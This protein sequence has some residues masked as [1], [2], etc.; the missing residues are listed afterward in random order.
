MKES[1]VVNASSSEVFPSKDSERSSYKTLNESLDQEPSFT[2][3]FEDNFDASSINLHKQ[4]SEPAH[5]SLFDKYAVFRELLEQ[6]NYENGPCGRKSPCRSPTAKDSTK[7]EEAPQTSVGGIAAPPVSAPAPVSQQDPSVDR[8]AALREISLCDEA[9][10]NKD[11]D[12]GDDDA[13]GE[14]GEGERENDMDGYVQAENEPSDKEDS[15]TEVPRNDEDQD[16]LTLSAQHSESTESPTNDTTTVKDT[17]SIMETTIMEEEACAGD[18]AT[19]AVSAVH[20]L[21]DITIAPITERPLEEEGLDQGS[22][23]LVPSSPADAR[24]IADSGS[25]LSED[26]EPPLKE[27]V[28]PVEVWAKFDAS[29]FDKPASDEAASPWSSDGKEYSRGAPA[30]W[31]DDSDREQVRGRRRRTNRGPAWREDE[32]SEEGPW[33]ENG[34]SDR[35]SLYDDGPAWYPEQR[36]SRRRKISPWRRTK[37]SREPSPWDSAE[38]DP[39][40][41]WDAKRWAKPADDDDGMR[42]W[43]TRPKNRGSSWE[44]ERRRVGSWEDVTPEYEDVRKRRPSPWSGEDR[45]SSRESMTWGDEERYQRRRYPGEGER[46]RHRGD[47]RWR[48]ER[49][50]EYRRRRDPDRD[51]ARDRERDRYAWPRKTASGDYC[52]PHRHYRDRDHSHDSPWDDEYSE[53]GEDSPHFQ[54]G[55]S[56]RKWRWSRPGSGS[57]Q[58]EGRRSHESYGG[59]DEYEHAGRR[60]RERPNSGSVERRSR[61]RDDAFNSDNEH[62]YWPEHARSRTERETRYEQRSQ[63]L[64]S[65]RSNRY[66]KTH[67]SPFEDDFTGEPKSQESSLELADGS[68]RSP[69][70]STPGTAVT[71]STHNAKV[72]RTAKKDSLSE[73]EEARSGR[74]RSSCG[75]SHRQSPFEDDFTTS[76]V[77]NSGRL[78]SASSDVSDQG[79]SGAD[80]RG[81]GP[82][83]S[84]LAQ[85]PRSADSGVFGS[86]SSMEHRN[87]RSIDDVFLPADAP[88]CAPAPAPATAPADAVAVAGASGGAPLKSETRRSVRLSGDDKNLAGMKAR[89]S[90]LRRADSSSSLRKSDSINIFARSSDP[91]DDDDF[92][93]GDSSAAQAKAKAEPRATSASTTA[94]TMASGDHMKWTDAFDSF[95]FQDE[96]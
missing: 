30:S 84:S 63:T 89:L 77:C 17:L 87:G 9:S 49:D 56:G 76:E 36:R 13:D 53:Q 29:R 26:A 6:D 46:E 23:N 96:Q 3:E 18:E 68:K 81:L 50:E 40:D 59:A 15:L 12:E 43:K 88:A 45:R 11:D 35:E 75:S 5:E 61:S 1:D 32:E 85:V 79:R 28:S 34:W 82:C 64:Q 71:T 39:E 20:E 60:Y 38:L 31:K 83:T 55:G 72:F 33:E 44:E 86:N 62:D 8:Y 21:R 93:N 73:S 14:D 66:R 70:S 19:E 57:S 27:G 10:S 65:W 37:P 54:S 80:E 4:S 42:A 7:E 58:A 52:R 67:R 69:L 22:S 51:R 48:T 78:M 90:S 91:F 92:F 95:N 74:G 47:R 94:S 16:L 2:A 41:K 25:R 24:S